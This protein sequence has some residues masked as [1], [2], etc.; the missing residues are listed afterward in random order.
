MV[1]ADIDDVVSR[2][3]FAARQTK[4]AGFTGVQIVKA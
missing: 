1:D 3:A 4:L 2:F